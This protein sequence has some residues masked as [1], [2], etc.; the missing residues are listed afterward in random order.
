M[1]YSAQGTP[2]AENKYKCPKHVE[3]VYDNKLHLLHQ[4]G[5]SRLCYIRCTVTHIFRIKLSAINVPI[6]KPVSIAINGAPATPRENT[7]LIT[8]CK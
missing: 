3:L 2:Y 5:S 4:V 8:L 7:G 1:W 6:H